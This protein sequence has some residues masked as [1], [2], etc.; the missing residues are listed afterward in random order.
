MRFTAKLVTGR[1]IPRPIQKFAPDL[2]NAEG[3]A[4]DFLEDRPPGIGQPVHG[5]TEGD[6]FDIYETREV[7]V[8]RLVRNKEG[9]VDRLTPETK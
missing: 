3:L 9:G 5:C 7:L 8:L 2:V 6:A 4:R 1:V